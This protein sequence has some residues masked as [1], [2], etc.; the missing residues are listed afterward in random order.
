MTDNIKQA[1]AETIANDKS[2]LDLFEDMTIKKIK[3]IE[4]CM[5]DVAM[6]YHELMTEKPFKE[7]PK[8]G[9]K[10]IAIDEC[11]M[12]EM[13]EKTL[14]ENKSQIKAKFLTRKNNTL[15]FVSD[16]K[17][18]HLE[19]PYQ[20]AELLLAKDAD[21]MLETVNGKVTIYKWIES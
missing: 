18:I 6:R 2:Y 5:E 15:I 8:V 3:A 20:N 16:G 13:G 4:K 10:L 17:P 12:D 11:I 14:T 9:D 1:I 19:F 21:Y 7:L